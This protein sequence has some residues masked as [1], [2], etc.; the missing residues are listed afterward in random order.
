MTLDDTLYLNKTDENSTTVTFLLPFLRDENI[1][2][3]TSRMG[4]MISDLIE[5]GT[6]KNSYSNFRILLPIGNT[7]AS[8]HVDVVNELFMSI[9]KHFIMV[10]TGHDTSNTGNHVYDYIRT[11]KAALISSNIVLGGDYPIP[12]GQNDKPCVPELL[13]NLPV[14]VIEK[15]KEKKVDYMFNITIDTYWKF[16]RKGT[17]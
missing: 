1:D 10:A 11:F 17:L 7:A 5:R 4:K 3:I 6:G 8:I 2:N 9:P 16:Q 14:T 13:Q 15:C 12:Y